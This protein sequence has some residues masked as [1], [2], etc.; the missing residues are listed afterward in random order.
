MMNISAGRWVFDTNL[1]IYASDSTSPFHERTR[2]L[3]SLIPEG[4]II[5]VVAH[6]N[7]IEAEGVLMKV[8]KKTP[9][10]AAKNLETI[11]HD[12]EFANIIPLMTT[13]QQFHVLLQK[14]TLPVDYF[15]YY[16]AATMLDNG[17]NRILTAN[18]KDFSKIP[19]IQAIN[20]F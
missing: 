13:L 2:E 10:Q 20:P 12:F 4:T 17:V 19:G 3:F 5:P 15:D 7:I 18:A 1:L 6:Q 16:L 9:S 11:L 8:Y 14:Q